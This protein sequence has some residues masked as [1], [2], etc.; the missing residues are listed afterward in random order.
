[1]S[2]TPLLLIAKAAFRVEN[3]RGVAAH[4]NEPFHAR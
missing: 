2:T 3:G 1:M 4:S